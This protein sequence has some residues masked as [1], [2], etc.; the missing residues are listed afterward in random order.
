MNILSLWPTVYAKLRALS[1]AS[2]AQWTAP[3]PRRAAPEEPRRPAGHLAERAEVLRSL[4]PPARPEAPRE[5]N[6][7]AESPAEQLTRLLM[8]KSWVD[9]EAADSAAQKR[10][11]SGPPPP[12]GSQR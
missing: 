3:A 4:Q 2:G 12:P 8:L 9:M 10:S 6:A 7:G 11:E 1:D 5:P